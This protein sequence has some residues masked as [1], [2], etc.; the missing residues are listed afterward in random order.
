VHVEVEGKHEQLAMMCSLLPRSKLAVPPLVELVVLGVLV[1][2]VVLVVLLVLVVHVRRQLRH[3]LRHRLT[4]R[5]QHLV[6]R[7]VDGCLLGW[8]DW[9]QL[10]LIR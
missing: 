1:V 3:Q 8:R 2:L 4:G 6:V 7:V 5:K 9:Q 10:P